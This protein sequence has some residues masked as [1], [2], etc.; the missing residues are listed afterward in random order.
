MVKSACTMDEVDMLTNDGI[1]SRDIVRLRVA[2]IDVVLT[3]S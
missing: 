3:C 1:A 2:L